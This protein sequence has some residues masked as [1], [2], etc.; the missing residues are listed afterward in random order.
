[1]F[2]PRALNMND[3]T[4]QIN[5]KPM[6]GALIDFGT[7]MFLI[8]KKIVDNSPSFFERQ[9]IQAVFYDSSLNF[10]Y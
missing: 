10:F 1:M 5:G 7:L 6:N 3:Q 9:V 4:I 8:G 2:R